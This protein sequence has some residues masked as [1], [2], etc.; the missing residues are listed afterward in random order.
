ME[1]TYK[2]AVSSPPAWEWDVYSAW[3]EKEYSDLL[4]SGAS[5]DEGNVQK[6]LEQH[7]CLVPGL[8]YSNKVPYPGALISQPRLS[9]VGLKVPDFLWI[10]FDSATIY[11]VFIEIETPH[12]SWYTSAGRMHSEFTGAYHQ[13]K[14][15]SAWFGNPTNRHAFFEAFRI[16][17]ELLRDR[18]CQPKFILVHGARAEIEAHRELNPVRAE[19]NTPDI[20]VATFDRLVPDHSA[21]GLWCVKNDGRDYHAISLPPT[22][23]IGPFNAG[24][25]SVYRGREDAIN[26]NALLGPE[27]KAF[28]IERLEYWDRWVKDGRGGWKYSGDWE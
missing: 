7:P 18:R 15:W 20:D 16:P 6:F 13:L 11:P 2:M 9:G 10:G 8:H 28:L 26:G 23:K 3:V 14:E 17:S 5:K 19:Y 21:H 27:R 12:K 22:F 24:D 1:R 25:V 4:R